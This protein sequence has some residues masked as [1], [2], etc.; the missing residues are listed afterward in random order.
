MANFDVFEGEALSVLK[1][2]PEAFFDT[3][4]TS[5]PYYKK[6]DYGHVDQLG[7]EST[8]ELFVNRLADIFDEIKRVLKPTGSLWANI[9]DTF[10]DK[11]LLGVPWL[12]A[13]ELKRRGWHLRGDAIWW[14]SNSA[15]E[16]AQ[17]RISRCHEYF[18]HF[19]KQLSGYYFNMDAIREPHTN[20]WALDCI[21]KFKANPVKRGINLFNKKERHSKNQKGITRADMGAALNPLGKHRR[22]VFT[23]GKLLRLK[24]NLDPDRLKLLIDTV[25]GI[26]YIADES[27]VPADFADLYEPVRIEFLS[28][29]TVNTNKFRGQHYAPYPKQLVTSAIIAT[30]PPDG[31]V[32][33]PF[34]GSG[35]TGVA[36]LENGRRFVGI[37]LV[38][39]SS[40]LAL[41]TLAAIPN[42]MG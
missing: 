26:N 1:D 12:L 3:C 40:Q 42:Q 18:F 41:Q 39:A 33:D 11:E 32:L 25:S 10:L 29:L 2:M 22:D 8:P 19:T 35:T 13:F 30:C 20:P 36:A 31:V 23:D 5:P 34:C 7:Q 37:E 14:K 6:R 9:D 17:N 16:A 38:P 27:E 4:A 28:L 21:A 24:P 15:P